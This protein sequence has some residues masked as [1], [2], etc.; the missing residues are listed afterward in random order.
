M[1]HTLFEVVFICAW[2]AA[3]SLCFDNF[4]TSLLPCAAEKHIRWYNQLPRP[5]IDL[6]NVEGTAGDEICESQLALICLVTVGLMT[7]CINLV[8]SLFR[9]VEKVKYHPVDTRNWRQS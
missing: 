1:F 4:F 6:H 5:T 8:I 9:I 2:S 7:Y 3:L